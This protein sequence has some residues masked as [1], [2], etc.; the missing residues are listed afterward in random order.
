MN[1]HCKFS[2]RSYLRSKKVGTEVQ[3]LLD[4]RDFQPQ[5]QRLLPSLKHGEV[6]HFGHFE[7]S[8]YS[9]YQYEGAYWAG[10]VIDAKHNLSHF[11][12]HFGFCITSMIGNLDSLLSRF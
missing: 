12:K 5:D 8:R 1:F 6:V 7:G 9:E 11:Y 4:E 10:V 3:Y 2:V